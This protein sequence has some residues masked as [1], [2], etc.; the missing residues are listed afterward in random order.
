MRKK[1]A[2]LM[3]MS[4]VLAGCGGGVDGAPLAAERWDP[5]SITPDAL[6]ATGLDPEYRLEGWGEGIEVPEWKRCVFHA[7]GG[8]D[9]PYGLNVMSSIDHT[10]TDAREDVS[11]RE[12]RDL[13]IGG[14]DAYMY[15]TD[16]DAALRDCQIAL[17]TPPGVV[18]FAVLY[19]TDDG[20]D[21]CEIVLKHVTDLESAV[22]STQQ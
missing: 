1:V 12:G 8:V 21:A 19:N 6:A 4:A 10:I 9:Y 5:C 20:A 2:T 18:V 16:F 14:R 3:A 11:N 7:V 17:A 22:P 15:Q 13:A